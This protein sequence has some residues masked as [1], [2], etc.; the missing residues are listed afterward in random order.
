VVVPAGLY[1]FEVFF[2]IIQAYVFSLLALM[3]MSQAVVS[4]HG[5]GHEEHAE[6]H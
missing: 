2:G 5:G 1:I 4:H 3:F 6:A